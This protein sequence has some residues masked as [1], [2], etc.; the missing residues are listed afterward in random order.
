VGANFQSVPTST[1]ASLD[2]LLEADGLA[3]PLYSSTAARYIGD[4]KK[5][6]SEQ[7]QPAQPPPGGKAPPAATPSGI[8]AIQTSVTNRQAA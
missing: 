7:A 2:L 6:A 5:L 8:S 4:A 3:G 1:K